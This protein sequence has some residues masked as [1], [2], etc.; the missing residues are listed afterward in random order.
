MNNM[1]EIAKYKLFYDAEASEGRNMNNPEQVARSDTQL[2][3]REC[4][5]GKPARRTA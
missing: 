1:D 3:V 2:G 5:K 4:A